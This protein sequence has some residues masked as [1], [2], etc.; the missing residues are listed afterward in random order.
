MTLAAASVMACPFKH[1]RSQWHPGG[2]QRCRLSAFSRRP[3]EAEGVRPHFLR[4][5][6]GDRPRARCHKGRGDDA[7]SPNLSAH[8][9][10]RPGGARTKRGRA[11]DPLRCASRLNGV[12]AEKALP[13]R[14]VA[15]ASARMNPSP[16]RLRRP[17]SPTRGEG[18]HAPHLTPPQLR[19]GEE[20][21]RINFPTA[22]ARGVGPGQPRHRVAG[23]PPVLRPPVARAAPIARPRSARG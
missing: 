15:A 19:G 12:A 6:N 16:G 8:T 18:M 5:E 4:A 10:V 2:D 21:H 9:P 1:W 17:P 14:A 20:Q 22:G 23:R 3:D 13:R 7:P 11:V